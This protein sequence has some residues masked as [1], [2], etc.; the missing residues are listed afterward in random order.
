MDNIKL[1]NGF[2]IGI[3]KDRPN[4]I[5]L[6]FTYKDTKTGATETKTKIITHNFV[7]KNLALHILRVINQKDKK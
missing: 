7:A 3:L 4:E 6:E 5:V 1:I 2:T